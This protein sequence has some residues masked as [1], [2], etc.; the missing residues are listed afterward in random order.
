LFATSSHLMIWLIC[1]FLSFNDVTHLFLPLIQWHDLFATSSQSMMWL[2]CCFLSFD[3]VAYLLCSLFF[4][5]F[6]SFAISSCF[7]T[8]L[9]CQFLS[10]NNMTHLPLFFS[11]SIMQ[12]CLTCF[13]LIHTCSKWLHLTLMIWLVCH[14]LFSHTS[15]QLIRLICHFLLFTSSSCLMQLASSCL[16]LPL[17]QCDFLLLTIICH[18]LSFD[19]TNLPLT[20]VQ[21]VFFLF[22]A[23]Q[24]PLTLDFFFLSFDVTQLLLPLVCHKLSFP[25]TCLQ[26]MLVVCHFISLDDETHLPLSLTGQHKVMMLAPQHSPPA[27]I[28]HSTNNACTIIEGIVSAKQKKWLWKIYSFWWCYVHDYFFTSKKQHKD[29]FTFAVDCGRYST[30]TGLCHSLNDPEKSI[31]YNFYEFIIPFYNVRLLVESKILAY[32]WQQDNIVATILLTIHN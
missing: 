26:L 5:L 20:P 3:N 12:L 23:T 31:N 18:I 17:F 1:H 14:F 19:A 15:S 7:A 2:I 30:N 13:L 29:I 32:S 27:T 4:L 8:W 9:I 21:C 11:C 22:D 25:T 10:F 6:N 16:L 24:L 28:F